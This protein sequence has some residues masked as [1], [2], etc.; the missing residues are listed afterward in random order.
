MLLLV[1]SEIFAG[2]GGYGSIGAF[3]KILLGYFLFIFLLTIVAIVAGIALTKKKKKVTGWPRKIMNI[4]LLVFIFF[5]I[6]F[7]WWVI[8]SMFGQP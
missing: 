4:Y 6:P 8:H 7:V 5:V 3:A 2:T 1:P